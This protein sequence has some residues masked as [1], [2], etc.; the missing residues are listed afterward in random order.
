[1]LGVNAA[2]IQAPAAKFTGTVNI[3]GLVSG[4]F[5]HHGQSMNDDA[6]QSTA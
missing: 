1:V 3:K 5:H 2:G 4:D 6:C